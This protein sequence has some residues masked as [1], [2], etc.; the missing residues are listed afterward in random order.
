VSELRER[1]SWARDVL[2]NELASHPDLSETIDL[3]DGTSLGRGYEVGNVAAFEYRIGEVPAGAQL[4][5]DLR[6][7]GGCSVACTSLLTER[8]AC[9]E[10]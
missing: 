3:G 7:L 2:I 6:F 1:V 10:K 5:A 8:L 4:E 9:P